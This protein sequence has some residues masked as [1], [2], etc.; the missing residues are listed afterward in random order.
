MNLLLSMVT[1]SVVFNPSHMDSKL[2]MVV[3]MA[4]GQVRAMDMEITVGEK[5][6]IHN[7]L[8]TGKVFK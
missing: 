1:I 5:R 6:N 4:F 2:A 8:V 3:V 7:R